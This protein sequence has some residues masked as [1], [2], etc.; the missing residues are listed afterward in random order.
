MRT[1]W[2]AI[3]LLSSSLAVG[4]NG[5]D[6]QNATNP[7][8]EALAPATGVAAAPEPAAPV[9]SSTAVAPKAPAAAPKPKPVAPRAQA[10]APRPVVPA[11]PRFREVTAPAGTELPLELTTALSSETAQL[12]A[13][14]SARLRRAVVIDGLTVFPAGTV[15]HGN[16]TEV[17]RAGRV[18]G[19]SHLAFRFTEVSIA[20]QRDRVATH[21]LNF[22][23][24]ATKSEDATKVGA[25]AGIGAVIGGIVGG[26][27]GA[28]KGALIGGAAGTGAVLA[29]RGR[30][31][32]LAAGS[33]V[34]ATLASPYGV[35]V[36]LE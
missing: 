8:P 21:S 18:K 15:F 6:E 19:R 16:V 26:G 12:E 28:A 20:E 30:D 25:G 32:E 22:E 35:R 1:Q 3:A 14:V 5:K 36:E 9:E 33:E 17:E 29:T 7:V 2:I 4:C 13:P 24:E 23:G 27:K 31:V 34:S 11:Q 10:A